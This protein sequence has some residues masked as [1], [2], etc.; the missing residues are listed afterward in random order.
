MLNVKRNDPI[1]SPFI[2]YTNSIHTLIKLK[3]WNWCVNC[4]SNWLIISFIQN[5]L[6]LSSFQLLKCRFNS[7]LSIKAEKNPILTPFCTQLT[8]IQQSTVNNG[9]LLSNALK[10]FHQWLLSKGLLN[11]TVKWSFVTCGDWDL[12]KMLTSQLALLKI[13]RETYFCNWVNLKQ[14]FKEVIKL[15]AH[16]VVV[17]LKM[18]KKNFAAVF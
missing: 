8:G 13:R 2:N 3:H 6:N 11:S 9:I 10:L 5:L 17:F 1:D 15:K 16:T 14:L 18:V 4:N 7:L 12:K